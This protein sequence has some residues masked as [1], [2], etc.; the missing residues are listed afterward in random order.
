MY[1]EGKG[2]GKDK[3]KHCEGEAKGKQIKELNDE[4]CKRFLGEKGN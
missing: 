3:E 2:K 4:G 1:N